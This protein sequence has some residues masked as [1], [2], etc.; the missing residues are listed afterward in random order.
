MKRLLMTTAAAVALFASCSSGDS[1]DSTTT[2]TSTSTSTTTLPPAVVD[3]EV[4]PGT[5]EGVEGARDDVGSFVCERSDEGWTVSGDVTNTTEEPV[6]Y[7][8]YTSF[9]DNARVTVGLLQTDV[10]AVA[11][12]ET[13]EWSGSIAVEADQVECILRVERTSAGT[14]TDS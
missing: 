2:T 5:S 13:Q 12:G 7:R 10:D 8:I 1:G 6:S 9:L 4:D 14:D 11:A 3:V